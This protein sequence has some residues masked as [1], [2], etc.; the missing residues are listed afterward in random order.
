[1]VISTIIKELSKPEILDNIIKNLLKVHEKQIV[2]I[3]VIPLLMQ[4]K[5]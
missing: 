1:M 3:W 4:E 2:K 5:K